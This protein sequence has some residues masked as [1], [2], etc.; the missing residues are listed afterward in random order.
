MR[1]VVEA[2][3]K[4]F[5]MA[6]QLEALGHEPVV[7]GPGRKKAIVAIARKLAS[8]L[9]SMWK[10]E[11][12]FDPICSTWRDDGEIL[13]S[14]RSQGEVSAAIHRI[15]CGSFHVFKRRVANSTV[16]S[17]TNLCPGIKAR[18]RAHVDG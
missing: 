2:S 8:V 6:N 7:V 12:S 9:W 14:P 1:I 4:S 3:T 16:L 18:P 13:T 17:K 5:W 15:E 10:R 11:K